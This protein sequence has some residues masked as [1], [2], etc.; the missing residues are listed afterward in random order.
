M[1]KAPCPVPPLPPGLYKPA[2]KKAKGN[3]NSGAVGG[4]V[5]QALVRLTRF[6]QSL[7]ISQPTLTKAKSSGLA[8][9]MH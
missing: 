8:L 6:Y 9:G 5:E 3:F 7:Q 4:K 2:A 1:T